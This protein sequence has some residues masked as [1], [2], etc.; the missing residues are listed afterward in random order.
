MSSTYFEEL[1]CCY[2][3][4]QGLQVMS[5]HCI[6]PVSGCICACDMFTCSD[7]S[8]SIFNIWLCCEFLTLSGDNSLFGFFFAC[9]SFY[10]SNRHLTSVYFGLLLPQ[11]WTN[12]QE[13][14]SLLCRHFNWG[15]TLLYI[16]GITYSDG[17]QFEHFRYHMI[18]RKCKILNQSTI[19]YI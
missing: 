15:L 10:S 5:K 2:W 9:T 7:K 14:F 1:S 17:I 4:N 3:N 6:L 8:R 16:S 11:K 18:W 19:M 12:A 13:W